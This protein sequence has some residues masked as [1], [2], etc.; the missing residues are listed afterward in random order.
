MSIVDLNGHKDAVV[1]PQDRKLRQLF[2]TSK[3]PLE[4]SFSMPDMQTK[5]KK[6]E[7]LIA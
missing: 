2:L 4:K 1:S 7:R 3:M 6:R 5:R